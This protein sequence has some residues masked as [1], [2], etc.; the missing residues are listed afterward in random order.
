MKIVFIVEKGTEGLSLNAE[1]KKLGIK[2]SSTRHV[3]FN[4]A[5]CADYTLW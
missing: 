2:G 1:E 3:F 4:N 5:V